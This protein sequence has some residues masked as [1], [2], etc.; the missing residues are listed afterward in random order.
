MTLSPQRLQE[1][2]DAGGRAIIS[3]MPYESAL[4]L[5]DGMTLWRKQV[6]ARAAMAEAI[7]R[8]SGFYDLLEAKKSG[9]EMAGLLEMIG[10]LDTDEGLDS[11]CLWHLKDLA[12]KALAKWEAAITKA[13][14]NPP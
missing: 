1:L 5:R 13:E 4:D 7:L 8:D 9:K 14:G 11:T 6:P 2:G 3:V 10:R 12:S